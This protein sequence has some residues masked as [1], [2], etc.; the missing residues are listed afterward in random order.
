MHGLNFVIVSITG[1]AIGFEVTDFGVIREP[2]SVFFHLSN[3]GFSYD[4]I[5][6]V[7]APLPCSDYPGDLSA[8]FS[9]IPA[10]SASLGIF[11]CIEFV[12]Y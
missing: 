4:D 6:V 5:P 12:V 3:S 8:L 7:V 11:I 9:D 1:A 10:A 2:E